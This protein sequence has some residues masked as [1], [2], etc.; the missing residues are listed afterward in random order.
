[1]K[2]A[3]IICMCGSLKETST[4]M[5]ETERLTLEGFNVISVIYETR[6]INSYTT[7]EIR[8]FV[9]LHY[10]KIDICDAIYVVNVNGYI[11]DATKLDIEYAKKRGK[12]VIYME[13][14]KIIIEI[15]ELEKKINELQ[16][17]KRNLEEQA[18]KK[19]RT[20]NAILRRK[21]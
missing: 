13:K 11:G 19:H 16:D 12:E 6:D 10:Q 9:E 15:K 17:K 8:K 1:M 7:E 20:R 2:K 3:K 4:L 14:T 5:K 21:K 18:F